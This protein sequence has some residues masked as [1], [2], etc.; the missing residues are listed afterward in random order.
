MENK[1][2]EKSIGVVLGDLIPILEK[3]SETPNLDAQWLL[4]RV[5]ER[6]SAWVLAHPEAAL[7]SEHNAAL[8]KMIARLE[9]GIPLPYVLGRWEFFGREFV[10]TPDVL[11]PRPETELLVERAIAWLQEHPDARHAADVGT[12]SGCIAV[13]LAADI[14]DLQVVASD[15]SAEALKIARQNAVNNGVEQRVEFRL[16]DLFPPE[17]VFDLIIANL[18]YVPTQ[19]LQALPIFGREP[20]LA[21]DGGTDGLAIIRRL[22]NAA[23]QFQLNSDWHQQNPEVN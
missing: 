19:V 10:V 20:A 7:T 21:L 2:R 6:S 17:A 5:M 11:I 9:D 15:I 3:N 8:E 1:I 14:H 12:G 23:H 18:P 13:A 16:C 22:L 4:A